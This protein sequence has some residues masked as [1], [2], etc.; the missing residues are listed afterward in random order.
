[1]IEYKDLLKSF[2]ENPRDI[3]TCPLNKRIPK[4]FYVAV[5]QSDIIIE[6]AKSNRPSCTI[7]KPRRLHK[8]EFKNMLDL[9]MRRT[10]GE[11]I[12]RQATEVTRNQVYWYGIFNDLILKK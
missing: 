1:M 9:Y 11:A 4:W 12:S 3:H 10:R 5:N 2:S 8:R 7:T 6:S